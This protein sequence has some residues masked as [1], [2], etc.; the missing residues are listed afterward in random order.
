MMEKLAN[1]SRMLAEVELR[2]V[3]G[4]RFQPTGF[5][6]LGAAIYTRPDGKRMNLLESAQ[7]MANRL[8]KVCIEGDG[9]HISKELEGLPYIFVKINGDSHAE[10]SSLI[11][12][13]RINSPY[14]IGNEQ[15]KN[16]FMQMSKYRDD[17]P[18]DWG[19]VAKTIFYFDPNSLIHGVFMANLGIGRVRTPRALTGF[20]EAEEVLEAASGG[21]KNDLIDPTGK[22]R[23]KGFNKDNVYGNVPYHRMEYT[24]AKIK[25]YFNLD[26]SLIRGYK[27]DKSAEELLIVLSLYKIRRFLSGGLRLRTSCDLKQ[28]GELVVTS[29]S[30]FIIPTEGALL[31]KIRVLID[32]CNNKGLFCPPNERVIEVTV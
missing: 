21:V 8:E 20:I 28:V 31:Q 2:P 27:L 13:H 12:A 15:F 1:A 24:A 9:P 17:Q 6:D 22:L 5:A 23:V 11:E 4:D 16:K 7:S 14:I 10:T 29:P 25:A 3:Q 19:A 30:G 32:E 18:L 26:L